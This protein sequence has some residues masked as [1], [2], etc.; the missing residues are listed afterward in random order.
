MSVLRYLHLLELLYFRNYLA[1]NNKCLIYELCIAILYQHNESKYRRQRKT[2]L[3][4]YRKYFH[5][6][7]YS[8]LCR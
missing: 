7:L 5:Q 3:P 6:S 2:F 8:I 4:C 1:F